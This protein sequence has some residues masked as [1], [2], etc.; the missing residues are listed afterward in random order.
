MLNNQNRVWFRNRTIHKFL[1]NSLFSVNR[2]SYCSS[3]QF[4]KL[5][6]P[7]ELRTRQKR[8][9]ENIFKNEKIGFNDYLVLIP[10]AKRTFQT[11]TIIPN[12]HFKQNSDFIYFT[13][14]N[15]IDSSECVLALIANNGKIKET[16]LYSP[17]ISE[18]QKVW[19]GNKFKIVFRTKF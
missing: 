2:S 8:L 13:G 5:I 17:T 16:N 1:F 12:I 15:R 6:T 3:S 14:L 7:V 19:E 9:V 4:T 11:D 18:H 10:A